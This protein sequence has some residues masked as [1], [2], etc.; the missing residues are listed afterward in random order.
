[1]PR[2]LF[3]ASELMQ[4]QIRPEDLNYGRRKRRNLSEMLEEMLDEN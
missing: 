2:D 3:V 1:L 4:S